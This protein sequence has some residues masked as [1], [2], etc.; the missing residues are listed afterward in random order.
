MSLDTALLS[1]TVRHSVKNSVSKLLI[2]L[3]MTSIWTWSA[4]QGCNVCS[5]HFVLKCTCNDQ[6]PNEVGGFVSALII[7][8]MYPAYRQKVTR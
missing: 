3:A 5:R 2:G 8:T 6:V 4:V 7:L 1:V